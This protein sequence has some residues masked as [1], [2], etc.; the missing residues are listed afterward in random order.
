MSSEHYRTAIALCKSPPQ[1][2]A[3]LP[4]SLDWGGARAPTCR[5]SAIDSWL[6]LRE[7]E[8]FHVLKAVTTDRSPRF[9]RVIPSNLTS[10]LYI[11]LYMLVCTCMR[12]SKSYYRCYNRAGQSDCSNRLFIGFLISAL[13]SG[14]FHLLPLIIFPRNTLSSSLPF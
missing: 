2:Q 1:E 11:W 13:L 10:Q 12:F 5:W 4:S 9:Q 7:G 6:L 8:R 14:C 3:K